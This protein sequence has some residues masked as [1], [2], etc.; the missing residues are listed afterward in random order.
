[1]STATATETATETQQLKFI[2]D[3]LK[4]IE[5]NMKK[6]SKEITSIKEE[7]KGKQIPRQ[8]QIADEAQATKV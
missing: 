8:K 2:C 3:K 1:M 7:I 6:L 4:L 5:T